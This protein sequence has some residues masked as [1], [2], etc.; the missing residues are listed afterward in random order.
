MPIDLLNKRLTRKAIKIQQPFVKDKMP[1]ALVPYGLYL[2]NGIKNAKKGDIIE[3]FDGWRSEQRVL[4]NK[5]TVDINSSVFSFLL[6]LIYGEFLNKTELFKRWNS[7]CVVE[8]YGRDAFN[9]DECVLILVEPRKSK[10]DD[11]K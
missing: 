11:W 2:N 3:F 5:C 7:I 10:D 4:V 8:G 9:P 1:M 6:K